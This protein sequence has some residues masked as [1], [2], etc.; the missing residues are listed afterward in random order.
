MPVTVVM[1]NREWQM[2]VWVLTLMKNMDKHDGLTA[3][4]IFTEVVPQTA[5][6]MV[7]LSVSSECQHSIFK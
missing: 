1:I 4:L 5:V 2:A 6:F 7:F 3:V